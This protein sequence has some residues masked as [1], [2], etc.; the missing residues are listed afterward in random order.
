MDQDIED[1]LRRYRGGDVDLAQ[2]RAWLSME[3]PRV[4]KQVQRGPLL[5]LRHGDDST[6]MAAVAQLLPAC[7]QCAI[8]GG[9]K[10]FVSRDE[11]RSYSQRRD[12]VVAARVLMEIA[13]PDWGGNCQQQEDPP[14]IIVARGADRCGYLSNRSEGT[15]DRGTEL[16]RAQLRCPITLTKRYALATKSRRQTASEDAQPVTLSF[17]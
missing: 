8:V 10:Q 17:G 3:T 7:T 6:A 13:P 11:Y 4:A 1:I 14:C 12:G 2:L 9:A 15:T 16:L 5:R